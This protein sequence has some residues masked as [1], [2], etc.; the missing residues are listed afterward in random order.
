MSRATLRFLSPEE[1]DR[2]HETSLRVLSEVG[3]AV[4]SPSVTKMLIAAGAHSSDDGHRVLIPQDMVESSLSSAPRSVLLASRLEGKDIRIP[5]NRLYCANGGEGVYIKD[6]L[7]GVT[8]S[9]T[10]ESVEKFTALI[11]ALP[12]IDMAWNMVGAIEQPEEIKSL[13]ELKIGFEFTRKHYQGG[14]LNATE[15]R[16]MVEMASLLAG[17]PEELAKKPIFSAIQCPISPL[18]FD[19]DLIEAQVELARSGIPVVSMSAAVAGLTSPATISGTIAQ[20]TAENLASL[21][22]CQVAKKGAPFVFSSDSSAGD[23]RT[24]SIQYDALESVLLRVAAAEMGRRYGLPVQSG[25]VG[26]ED[27]ALLLSRVREGI[28]YMIPHALVPSDLSSGFG[29]VDQAAG[30]SYELMIVDA[31]VWDAAREFVRTFDADDAAIS[32]DTIKGAALDNSFLNKRHTAAHFK[33]EFAST[34]NPE[35]MLSSKGQPRARGDL[36]YRAKD[37]VRR[38]LKDAKP[39]ISTRESNELQRIVDR[40]RKG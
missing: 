21:T 36:L 1:I 28:P 29:G 26:L 13:V 25:A 37:E 7:T 4:H 22:I 24:G 19:K 33:K 32:F 14:A 34:R 3:V 5:D 16:L 38:I 10:K 23:L 30:A 11:E 2:I 15:A 12:M 39:V 20:V 9:P 8:T 27:S 40:A 17:G 6:M 35:A 18:T 31:W